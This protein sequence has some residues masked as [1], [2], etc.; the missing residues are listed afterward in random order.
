[1]WSARQSL[2]HETSTTAHLIC[3]IHSHSFVLTGSTEPPGGC[4]VLIIKCMPH[5]CLHHL[6]GKRSQNS[7]AQN[8][9]VAYMPQVSLNVPTSDSTEIILKYQQ[10]FCLSTPTPPALRL[11][12]PTEEHPTEERLIV[13]VL[14]FSLSNSAKG[15]V[16]AC[17]GNRVF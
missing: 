6:Q 5:S 3:C 16:T 15:G 9:L 12:F 8:G 1:M 10:D 17:A 14:P 7:R 4:S 2:L 11:A 13:G